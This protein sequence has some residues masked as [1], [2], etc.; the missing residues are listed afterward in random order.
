MRLPSR[1]VAVLSLAVVLI[2]LSAG[3]ASAHVSVDSP[4]ATQGGYSVI[5]FRVPTESATLSTTGLRVQLPTDTPFASVSV[6]PMTGWNYTVN[7]TT[8]TTPIQT[9]DGPVTEAISE[10]DWTATADGIKPGEFLEFKISAGPLP[11]KSSVTFKVIQHYS[12]NTDVSWVEVAAPGSAEP[13][14]PAPTLDLA[15]AAASGSSAH[16][17]GSAPATGTASTATMDMAISN[18]DYAKQSAVTTALITSAIAIFLAAVGFGVGFAAWR[19]T[20]P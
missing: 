15:P 19:R 16:T 10:V 1:L 17:T 12:D 11:E 6:E 8:L 9:D 14:H 7:K 20:R 4:G 18:G 5:T 13:E 2:G 3:V